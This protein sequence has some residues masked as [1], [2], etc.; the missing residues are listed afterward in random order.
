SLVGVLDVNM[1]FQPQS[2]VALRVDPSAVALRID[3][4]TGLATQ[5]LRNGYF[6][7]S[8]R[9]VAAAPG[10]QAAGLTDA[11]PLGGNRSWGVGARGKTYDRNNY[12]EAFVRVVSDGYLRAMG[13]Q[14]RAGRD[15]TAADNPS[16][17]RVIIVNESL[18]RTLWP[19]E[20]PLGQFRFADAER[21]VVAVVR[22][23]RPLALEREPGGE[24]YFP[25]RQPN[26]S[27]PVPLVAR[28][29]LPPA[30]LA[31]AVRDALRPVDPS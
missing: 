31:G 8:P 22:E 7:E 4:R 6:D 10:V 9:R 14:M 15:F 23:V 20:D 2:A 28:G 11:L 24:M 25:I 29:P 17:P 1:G 26:D 5:A 13:I 16:S 27:S 18:A 30:S 3:P 12:P 19:G 21:Q